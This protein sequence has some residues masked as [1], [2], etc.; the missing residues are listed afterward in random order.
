MRLGRVLYETETKLQDFV[1]DALAV[2]VEL[3]ERELGI[4][5]E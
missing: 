1:T 2:M 3:A 5:E 4:R